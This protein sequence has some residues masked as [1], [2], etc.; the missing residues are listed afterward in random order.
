ME[1]LKNYYDICS[2]QD[3]TIQPYYQI[4]KSNIT[5]TYNKY[6]LYQINEKWYGDDATKINKFVLGA[7]DTINNNEILIIDFDS[8]EFDQEDY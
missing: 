8:S 5:R 3:Q 7:K 4:N 2:I 6:L 1:L